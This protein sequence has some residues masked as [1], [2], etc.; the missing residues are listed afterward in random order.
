MK[1]YVW[2]SISILIE[3]VG[4]VMLKLSDGFTSLLPSVGAIASYGLSFYLL[5]L[6]LTY[7][8]LSLAYAIWSGTGTALTAIAGIIIWDE[9]ATLLKGIGILL[10]IGGVALLNMKEPKQRRKSL[11]KI[12]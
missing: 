1:P 4:T 12:N 8:P 3:T 7:L 2:L 6:C 9:A 5:S 10:I 11:Q